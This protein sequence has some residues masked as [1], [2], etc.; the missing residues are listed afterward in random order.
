MNSR[1]KKSK[2]IRKNKSFLVNIHKPF[3]LKIFSTLVLFIVL[4]LLLNY[5][6]S[7]HSIRISFEKDMTE[8]YAL[9]SETLFSIDSI[10]LYHSANAKQNTNIKKSF[11]LDIY[12]FTDISFQITNKKNLIIKDFYIDNITCS[13]ASNNTSLG[14][15][16]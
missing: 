14:F 13:L 4:I 5:T 15:I 2:R 9:N 11:V 1:F 10:T 8:F 12:Q 7:V 3:L 16:Y 6:W